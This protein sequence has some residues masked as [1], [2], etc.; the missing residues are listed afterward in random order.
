MAEFGA[1]PA[2]AVALENVGDGAGLRDD[3]G[4]GRFAIGCGVEAVCDGRAPLTY[5]L[6]RVAM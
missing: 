2:V 6:R 4:I 1:D 5:R 3:L